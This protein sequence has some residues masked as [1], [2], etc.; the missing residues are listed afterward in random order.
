MSSTKHDTAR[1]VRAPLLTAALAALVFVALVFVA[2]PAS[3][4][5][6]LPWVSGFDLG[7]HTWMMAHRIAALASIAAVITST[8]SSA[9]AAPLV[10]LVAAVL[11]RGSLRARLVRAG[12]VLVVMLSPVLCRYGIPS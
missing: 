9:F 7:V 6:A 4:S 1:S 2:L 8:A 12:L 3:A 5:D 10:F 11:T